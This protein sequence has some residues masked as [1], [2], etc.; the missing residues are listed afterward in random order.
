[1]M[2]A[3]RFKSEIRMTKNEK[4]IATLALR[5]RAT[6]QDGEALAATLAEALQ[7]HASD[8]GILEIAHYGVTVEI[9]LSDGNHWAAECLGPD[10]FHLYPG[11]VTEGCVTWPN[12]WVAD[13]YTLDKFLE[14]LKEALSPAKN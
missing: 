8:V 9:E 12:I 5:M 4:L 3:S 13:D 1:M 10:A 11:F 14:Y 6:P 7:E 2:T